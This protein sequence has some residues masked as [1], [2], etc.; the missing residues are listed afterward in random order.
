MAVTKTDIQNKEFS[1]KS[2]GY[3]K[4]EVDVFLDEII[5]TFIAK[6]KEI[7]SLQEKCSELYEKINSYKSMDSS[8][9]ELFAI[10][11]MKSDEVVGQANQQAEEIIKNAKEKGDAM[12]AEVN[13]EL[14]TLKAETEK[15]RNQYQIFCIK[16]EALLQNQL[17]LLKRD[18]DTE[19]VDATRAAE[20]S[21]TEK[22]PAKQP[23]KETEQTEAT[24]E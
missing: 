10:A 13:G 22:E 1:T 20:E 15:M 21:P 19:T 24:V 6:D 11:K 3:D 2:K 14:E 18:E 23:E 5:D 17:K 12:L 4:Y 7:E 8:L 9:V 16:F